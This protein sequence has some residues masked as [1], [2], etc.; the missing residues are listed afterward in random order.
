MSIYTI[1]PVYFSLSNLLNVLALD[2]GESLAPV[3]IEDECVL[4]SNAR[5]LRL[6]VRLL[7]IFAPHSSLKGLMT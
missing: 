7:S 3:V 4:I 5:D 6:K 1:I 2:Q